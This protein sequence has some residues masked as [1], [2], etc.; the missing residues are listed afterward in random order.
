M[1][2][3]LLTATRTLPGW[4]QQLL[5]LDRSWFLKVNTEWTGSLGD[6]LFPILRTPENW[7]PL[8]LVLIA[9]VI[10]KYK[11]KAISWLLFV[12]AI[13]L[14]ADQ[15]SS[16]LIKPYFGRVRPCNE[17]ALQGIMHMLL[18]YCGGNGSFTSSHAVNH[19]ALAVFFHRSLRPVLGKW[20]WGF[21]GWAAI[22]CYAQVYVGAHYPGDVMA[23]ALLGLLIGWLAFLVFRK[24]M[25]WERPPSKRSAD[26]C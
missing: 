13:V 17:P 15:V 2:T 8:Y 11:W 12:A 10:Y 26:P 3:T 16:S 19:F 23:G 5:L 21:Y 4:L 20:A 9:L 7:I 25:K 6:T 24:Y 18:P 22:I 1:D 14:V